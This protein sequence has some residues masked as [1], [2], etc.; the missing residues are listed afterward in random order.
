MVILYRETS[1]VKDAIA[2]VSANLFY[3]KE[4]RENTKRDLSM[5]NLLSS[6][7]SARAYWTS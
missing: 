3:D 7:A 1:M 5:T 2:S 6:E 4:I